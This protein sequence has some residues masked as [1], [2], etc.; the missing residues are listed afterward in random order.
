[1]AYYAPSSPACC[2]HPGRPSR[3]SSWDRLE[4]CVPDMCIYIDMYAIHT[5]ASIHSC[6]HI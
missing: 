1:M 4:R 3:L 6:I 5:S 2:V